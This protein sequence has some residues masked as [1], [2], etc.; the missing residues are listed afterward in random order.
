MTWTSFSF[1]FMLV[2][3]MVQNLL[4]RNLFLQPYFVYASWSQDACKSHTS[5]APKWLSGVWMK[6]SSDGRTNSLLPDSSP[7]LHTPT[8]KI[9]CWSEFCPT[10]T[11]HLFLLLG[12]QTMSTSSCSSTLMRVILF[13]KFFSRFKTS[14]F[15]Q[16]FLIILGLFIVQWNTMGF[17]YIFKKYSTQH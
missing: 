11:S 15:F 5:S 16:L 4:Q 14:L 17:F 12:S 7:R 10:L 6:T 13:L 3:P 8:R 9:I 1:C 2:D